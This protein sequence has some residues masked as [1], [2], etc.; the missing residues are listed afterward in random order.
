[1]RISAIWKSGL[2]FTAGLWLLCGGGAA[3]E[4]GKFVH[5]EYYVW[6]RLEKRGLD[7]KTIEHVSDLY[8]FSLKPDEQGHLIPSKEFVAHLAK[9]KQ[10]K[11]K[12]TT[13]WLGLGSLDTVA[14]DPAKFD[15]F[16][17]DL[18]TV[19]D[20]HNFPAI[21]VDWE[22]AHI[23]NNDY[24]RALKRISEEFR[25][26]R[27]V[28]ISVGSA[29]WHYMQKAKLTM[30]YVDHVNIQCYYSIA[31]SW[32][33]EEMGKRLTTFST[34]SGV[35]KSKILV[36]LPLYGQ[37]DRN[38]EGK[39]LPGIPYRTMIE[40]GAD[41]TR[42]TWNDTKLGRVYHYSGVP[43]IKAK[44]RYAREQGYAGVF[45][46]DISLDVPYDSEHS[47]LRAIDEVVAEGR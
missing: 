28:A 14:K 30:D 42:N 3:E 39:I 31:N 19:C 24:E 37:P 6:D 33:V 13:L 15:I 21:D 17:K 43:L 46:W 8:Y 20:S 26:E 34:T 7:P 45:T 16:I 32:S 12:E 47:I 18:H 27:K 40:K 41:S 44:T 5:A 23:D 10:V 9:L 25:P 35:P 22:G 2:I 38:E 36:G 4:K 1:M 11:S 29:S